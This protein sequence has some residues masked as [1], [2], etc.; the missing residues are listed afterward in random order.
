MNKKRKNDFVSVNVNELKEFLTHIINNNRYLQE[1]GK[2]SVS[3]EVVGES[4]IGKTSSIIQ[5]ANEL[6]L[7]FVKLNLAQCAMG[8]C[9]YQQRPSMRNCWIKHYK[10]R[11]LLSCFGGRC[12]LRKYIRI[13][14]NL[15]NNIVMV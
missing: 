8:L 9:L 14:R 11:L 1:N 15:C 2:P 13:A 10:W 6:D 4:G 12:Q 7:H 3:I 5:L